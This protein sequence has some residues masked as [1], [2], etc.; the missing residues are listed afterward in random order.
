[1]HPPSD[2]R[3]HLCFCIAPSRL[4]SGCSSTVG[5]C[6]AWGTC[7]DDRPDP[8]VFCMMTALSLAAMCTLNNLTNVEMRLS[9]R[10]RAILQN[11]NFKSHI[12][13]NDSRITRFTKVLAILG[14]LYIKVYSPVVKLRAIN[15]L[16]KMQPCCWGRDDCEY[17]LRVLDTNFAHNAPYKEWTENFAE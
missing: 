3:R 8:A 4:S 14:P 5:P 17:P 11:N 15:S 7:W 13:L 6:G 16:D 10:P 12:T 1:M 2:Y 9:D